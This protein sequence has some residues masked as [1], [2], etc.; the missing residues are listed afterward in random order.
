MRDTDFNKVKSVAKIFLYLQVQETSTSPA[1]VQ[2]PFI[3]TGFVMLK[4]KEAP[5]GIIINVLE[6]KDGL[7][8][9]RNMVE[10]E[11][12][13]AD[14]IFKL[15]YLI[16]KP[17]RMV[18]LKHIAPYLSPA[19]IGSYLNDTWSLVEYISM[20]VDVSKADFVK[21]L[22][23]SDPNTLMDESDRRALEALTDIVEIYRGVTDYNHRHVKS[24]SWSLD[25]GKARWFANRFNQGGY[26]YQATI[27]KSDILAYFAG[28][29]E[30]E[31]VVDPSKLENIELIETISASK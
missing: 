16:T 4:D 31:V 14:S 25:K 5:E 20:D 30:S 11:I 17:Y 10:S 19:D 9:F 2:H 27:K 29:G 13:K 1:V 23:K 6:D 12:D 7:R 18:L 22:K 15:T 24:L 26:V 3:A 8:R 28:R 21:L